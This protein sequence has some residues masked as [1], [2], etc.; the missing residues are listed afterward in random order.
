MNNDYGSTLLKGAKL[1]VNCKHHNSDKYVSDLQG[2][3]SYHCKVAM[4]YTKDT[5]SCNEFVAE[6]EE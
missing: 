1:C 5:G 6:E 2:N 4:G 3:K